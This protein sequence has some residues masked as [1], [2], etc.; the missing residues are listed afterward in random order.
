LVGPPGTKAVADGIVDAFK[1][2]ID[3][4]VNGLEPTNDRGW[5]VK[6]TEG[7]EG[8]VYED[9]NVTVD[10]F[11]VCHGD[12]DYALGYKFTTPDRVI[13]ISG[14]TGYC[15]IIGEKAK[16]GDILIHEVYGERGYSKIPA[17]WQAYHAAFHTSS[18]QLAELASAAQPGVLILH[19]QL[20]WGGDAY[21]QPYKELRQLYDGAI[22]D[23]YDFLK[24]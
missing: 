24:Y 12:W 15:P 7:Y 16:G 4:R 3:I 20:V 17:E 22:I 19:H 2:D 1:Q 6:T 21:D 9:D 13:V 23:G 10:A 14:G 11:Q 5:R 18:S 8:I